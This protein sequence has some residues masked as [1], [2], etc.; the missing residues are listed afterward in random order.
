MVTLTR[1]NNLTSKT[2]T[3]LL[4][5]YLIY[6]NGNNKTS[7][8]LISLVMMLRRTYIIQMCTQMISLELTSLKT[9]EKPF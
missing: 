1:L 3:A 4:K 6:Q 9:K 5:T 8:V 7:F 2:P